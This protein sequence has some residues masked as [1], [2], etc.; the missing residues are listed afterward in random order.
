METQD[1]TTRIIRIVTFVLVGWLLAQLALVGIRYFFPSQQ[2]R[3]EESL[4]SGQRV[5]TL[6]AAYMCKPVKTEVDF[7]DEPVAGTEDRYELTLGDGGKAVFSSFGG[8]LETAS[9]VKRQ[10][11][12]GVELVI[13]GPQTGTERE[14]RALLVA[15]DEKTPFFY[16]R[17]E[18]PASFVAQTEQLRVTKSYKTDGQLVDLELTVE[19]LI[20]DK[21]VQPRIFIP[22]P[23]LSSIGDRNAGS[24]FVWGASEKLEKIAANRVIGAAWASPQLV[25]LQSRYFAFGLVKDEQKFTRR[26]Y[27]KHAPNGQLIAILEGP[28]VAAKTTWHLSFYLG[29]KSSASF[30]AV[31]TRLDSLL[32]YGWFS[33]VAKGLMYLVN[34]INGFV[35][36]YGW[37]IV[38]LTI[39]LNLLLLP[40]TWK[41][42]QKGSDPAE[43]ARKLKYVESKYADDPERLREEKLALIK[44]YG[45]FPGLSGCLPMLLQIPVFAGLGS[46]L[47]SSFE[48]YQAPFI[49]WLK[50]LSAQDPYYILPALFGIALFLSLL[51]NIKTAR[52]Y[53]LYF[54]MTLI[55]SGFM[56]SLPSGLAL[57]VLVSTVARLLQ[58]WLVK[59]FKRA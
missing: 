13:I 43:Y 52:Q 56:V 55:F 53:A 26:A 40:F 47:R 44:K 24:A 31:D 49:W 30:A 28:E 19:P 38:L 58:T 39:L 42:D 14:E 15:F 6:P 12:K 51:P 4:K 8:G 27:F 36:N 41:A 21:A 34:Y 57:Y 20:A 33:Y 7:I 48:L 2:A 37:A 16:K 5:E 32:E 23:L 3:M 29:P 11:G 9:F 1:R 54:F 18:A 25:G 50:D 59:Q 46:A 22:T 10:D 35:H 45:A 17:A